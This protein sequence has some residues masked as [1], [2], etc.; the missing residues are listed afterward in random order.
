M[1]FQRWATRL[2]LALLL[3]AV[4]QF[5][6]LHR[7]GHA[8][9]QLAGMPQTQLCDACLDIAALDS[10]AFDTGC[11]AARSLAPEATSPLQRGIAALVGGAPGA[12]RSRAPPRLA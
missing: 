3:V 9:E 11:A 5:G 1:I 2:F 7:L 6:A 12:Y 4:Q 10:P 8:A